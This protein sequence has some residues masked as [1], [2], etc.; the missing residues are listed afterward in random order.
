[1]DIY[2]YPVGADNDNAPW[3]EKSMPMKEFEVLCS[4]TLS[5]V[6]KVKTNDYLGSEEEPDT[7]DTDWNSAYNERHYTALGLINEFKSVLQE[8]LKKHKLSDKKASYYRELLS[9]CDNWVEDDVEYL[10]NK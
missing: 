6:T 1:M 9:E 5:K 2:N 8:L 7:T 4:Q 3:W 10:E